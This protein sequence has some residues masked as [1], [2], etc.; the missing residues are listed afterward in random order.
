MKR[1]DDRGRLEDI[2]DAI[3]R[4]E[5]YMRGVNEKKFEYDV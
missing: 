2:L 4:I 1:P 3:K 5:S